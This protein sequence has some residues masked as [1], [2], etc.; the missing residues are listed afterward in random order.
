ILSTCNR[1]EITLTT[2]DEA[3][4]AAI[5]DEFLTAHKGV[6]SSSIGPH[7]YRHQGRDAIHHLFRVAASLDSMVIGEPQILGQ[8]KAAYAAAKEAGAVCG[9][10]DGLLTRSFSVAKRVRS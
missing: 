4:P 1:V 10:L 2:E 7:L 5:V 6:S 3:D 8:L 9:W